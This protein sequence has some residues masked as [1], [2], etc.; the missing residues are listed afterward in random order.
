M[1][2]GLLHLLPGE[3]R[4]AVLAKAAELQAD[5]NLP[6]PSMLSM[7]YMPSPATH[8]RFQNHISYKGGKPMEFMEGM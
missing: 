2:E 3:K 4:A 7:N 5:K 6:L 1:I 8:E